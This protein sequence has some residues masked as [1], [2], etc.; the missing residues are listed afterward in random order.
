MVVVDARHGSG[1]GVAHHAIVPG[2]HANGIDADYAHLD[3]GDCWMIGSGPNGASIEIGVELKTID[4]FLTSMQESRLDK[5][6]S[7][8]GEYGYDRVY[9]VIIGRVR[10]TWR[11]AIEVQRFDQKGRPY[12]QEPYVKQR[13]R[14]H[15]MSGIL[16]YQV[17]IQE[18]YATRVFWCEDDA[19]AAKVIAQI[20]NWWAKDWD[21]HGAGKKMPTPPESSKFVFKE[22]PFRARCAALVP[23][24]GWDKANAAAE[25]YSSLREMVNASVKDW[26]KVPGVGKTLAQRAY[27]LFREGE[28]AGSDE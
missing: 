8:M 2:L 23:K 24:F 1:K 10:E 21:S 12:W 22:P 4:D 9:L 20:H 19:G 14:P 17:M 5:Q 15:T 7:T 16:G 27:S 6:L 26:T 28:G 25:Y 11:G 13:G 18:F 3:S